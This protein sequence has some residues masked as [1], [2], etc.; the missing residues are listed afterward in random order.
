[1]RSFRVDRNSSPDFLDTFIISDTTTLILF[2]FF[3]SCQ[4]LL[5]LYDDILFIKISNHF[6]IH[7]HKLTFVIIRMFTVNDCLP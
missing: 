5:L 3:T 7:V 2:L 6:D 1:M 4:S